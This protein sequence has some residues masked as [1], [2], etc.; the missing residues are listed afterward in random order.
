MKKAMYRIKTTT[1]KNGRKEIQAQFKKRF[2]WVSLDSVGRECDYEVNCYSRETAIER[3]DFH[4]AGSS[5]KQT[6]EFE[7]ISK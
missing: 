1:F 7:Y 4:F 6:I 2:H 3:I 5:I